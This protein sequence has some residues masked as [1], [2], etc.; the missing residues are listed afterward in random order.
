VECRRRDG[1]HSEKVCHA[2]C[3]HEDHCGGWSHLYG[4]MTCSKG[5]TWKYILS[6]SRCLFVLLLLL[7]LL[8]LCFFKHGFS[9]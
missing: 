7:L 9:V 3:G 5:R 6:S 8:L 1:R 2:I 4:R